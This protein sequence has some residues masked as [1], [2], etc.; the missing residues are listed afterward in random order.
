M[1]FDKYVVNVWQQ[2]LG[3]MEKGNQ[4]VTLVPT[5]NPGYYVLK[6]ETDKKNLTTIILKGE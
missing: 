3:I 5:I 2:Y 6:L 1:I 4:N